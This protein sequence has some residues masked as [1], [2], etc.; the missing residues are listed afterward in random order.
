MEG[1]NMK[2][3]LIALPLLLAFA[4]GTQLNAQYSHSPQAAF[5]AYGGFGHVGFFYRPLLQYGE[6]IEL[7]PGF[8]A[9]R[10]HRLSYGWHPY[11]IGQWVW[12]DYGWYWISQEPYGWAVYHYGRWFYDD[13]YGWIWIPHDVWG[14]AWVEWRYDDDYIGWA[15]LPPYAGFHENIG[16]HFTIAWNAPYNYWCFVQHHHFTK[17]N[18]SQYVA[19]STTTRRLITTTRSARQYDMDRGAV[20]NRGIDRSFIEKQ[21]RV[22]ID[23]YR[24]ARSTSQRENVIR[25]SGMNRIESYRPD[26]TPERTQPDRISA[27][28]A[29]RGSSLQIDRIDR[30]LRENPAVREGEQR[31]RTPSR[32]DQ[33]T[34]PS[35]RIDPTR[36]DP[37]EEQRTRTREGQKPPKKDQSAVIAPTAPGQHG[38]SRTQG[39]PT[40]MSRAPGHESTRIAGTPQRTS[41]TERA[42]SS[43]STERKKQR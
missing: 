23:A 6:W 17:G 5:H 43:P 12:S 32:T 18:Y 36:K 19:S 39:A 1:T 33:Q 7:Q 31:G 25:S 38:D 41:P 26:P 8:Y 15:P 22:R 9:W 4:F 37:G 27:R 35:T 29:S 14:P 3:L 2:R 16:I 40:G 28:R 20:F 10:P 34:T 30:T 21:G 42:S 13:Y 24:V 11:M